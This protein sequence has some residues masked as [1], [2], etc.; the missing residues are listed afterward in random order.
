MV[1]NGA[2]LSRIL[3]QGLASGP[4][5]AS[6][7]SIEDHPRRKA[8]MHWPKSVSEWR[9]LSRDCPDVVQVMMDFL[10]DILDC[11]IPISLIWPTGS[12]ASLQ[13]LLVGACG[14]V[15]SILGLRSV[16]LSLK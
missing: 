10:Q 12:D 3:S 16:I 2:R 14:T 6:A 13:P 8:A 11:V 15:T 9:E 1:A 4:V 7:A 5:N